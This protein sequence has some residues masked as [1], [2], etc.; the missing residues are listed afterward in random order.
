M[1][2]TAAMEMRGGTGYIEE[3]VNARLVRDAQVGVLWDGTSNIVA[4]DAID[5]AVGRADAQLPLGEILEEMLAVGT[6]VRPKVAEAIRDAYARAARL[7]KRVS[8]HDNPGPAARKAAGALYHAISAAVLGW[9]GAVLT[10]GGSGSRRLD[11]AE[12]VLRQRL[13]PVD[14]LEEMA[15]LN[16][17][18]VIARALLGMGGESVAMRGAAEEGKT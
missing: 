7:A 2:A 5:R 3:W 10:A 9:E 15:G 4:L 16:D 17:D 18:D 11:L 13:S 1:V 8:G 12:Q 6:P 14:P